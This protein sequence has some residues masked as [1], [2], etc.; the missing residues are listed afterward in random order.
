[1]IQRGRIQ[2]ESMYYEHKKREGSLPLIGVGTFLQK[3]RGGEIELI[4]STEEE[5]GAQIAT[6]NAMVKRGTGLLQMVSK[7]CRGRRGI[8]GLYSSS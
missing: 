7:C 3:D 2:E 6:S 5:K 1:M 4:R 8:G